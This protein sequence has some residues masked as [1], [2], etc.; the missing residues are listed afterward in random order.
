MKRKAY[1]V[2]RIYYLVFIILFTGASYSA[3]LALKDRISAAIKKEI[4]K[5]YTIYSDAKI[6]LLYSRASNQLIDQVENIHDYGTSFKISLPQNRRISSSISIPVKISIDNKIEK[7]ISLQTKIKIMAPILAAAKKIR[8]GEVLNDQNISSV[9]RDIAI[10]PETVVF[11]K[12]RILGKEAATLIPGGAVVLDWMVRDIPII[13]KGDSVEVFKKI[14]GLIVKSNAF[15]LED[16]FLGSVIRVKNGTSH[17][18]LDAVVKNSK[19][20]EAP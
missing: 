1:L 18:V 7:T 2:K 19:E 13:R 8:K 4:L 17:K 6:E 16:G 9:E 14:K 12:Q 15:A 20:V 3:D 10:L 11:D 5:T